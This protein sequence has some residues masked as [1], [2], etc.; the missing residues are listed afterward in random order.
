MLSSN[1][2]TKHL[3]Q[4]LKKTFE[5]GWLTNYGVLDE[6]FSTAVLTRKDNH[7]FDLVPHRTIPY[8]YIDD[9]KFGKGETPDDHHV[10]WFFVKHTP[11]SGSGKSSP[12]STTSSLPA[13]HAGREPRDQQR[14]DSLPRPLSESPPHSDSSSTHSGSTRSGDKSSTM[15]SPTLTASSVASL[16]GKELPPPPNKL[17]IIH[18]QVT[19][20]KVP[21]HYY[22]GY[23]ER[24][25]CLLAKMP[26]DDVEAC[27][28][29][30]NVCPNMTFAV[31]R[32]RKEFL[33]W[34]KTGCNEMTW[35]ELVGH[36][37]LALTGHVKFVT[38]NSAKT[39]EII[40]A[41]QEA[42]KNAEADK[43]AEAKKK[44]P[45]LGK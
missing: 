18:S 25:R 34:I 5:D 15:R 44:A 37:N 30:D 12:A 6:E 10:F 42:D 27:S 11:A 39:L 29:L 36:L 20:D 22:V 8:Q 43:K 19:F 14:K 7:E 21:I 4:V 16:G 45:V 33:E 32:D 23:D 13:P 2:G 40:S 1:S 3:S 35:N 31:L 24:G 28:L 41:A 9:P 26:T 38:H 17:F